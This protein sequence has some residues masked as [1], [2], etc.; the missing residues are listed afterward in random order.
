MRPI[1]IGMVFLVFFFGGHRLYATD[2]ENK[3]HYNEKYFA[4]N[5]S[6]Y[7]KKQL[8]CIAD[9]IYYEANSESRMGKIAIARVIM[10]RVNDPRFPDDPCAVVYDGAKYTKEKAHL[11]RGKCQF[12][13]LCQ[14]KKPQ[15]PKLQDWL[16]ALEIAV[17][18]YVENKYTEIV[19]KSLFF[20]NA[21]ASPKWK[22]RFDKKIGNHLFYSS[23]RR[24]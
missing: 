16:E 20:H 12:S 19:P 14:G 7:Q 18:V 22:Y 17:D 11:Q 10:N 23:P 4:E 2:S 1:V 21:G 3:E 8:E 9:N 5:H 15:R 6:W 13:W 24:K